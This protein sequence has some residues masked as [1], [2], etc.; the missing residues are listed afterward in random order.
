[1]TKEQMAIIMMFEFSDKKEVEFLNDN[2]EVTQ[3]M[4]KDDFVKILMEG[5]E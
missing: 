4:A 1:M 2:G 5:I 3:K